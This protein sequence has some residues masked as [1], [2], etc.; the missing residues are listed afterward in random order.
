MLLKL[1][2]FCIWYQD[3]LIV[4][5]MRSLQ[6]KPQSTPFFRKEVATIKE[7][8]GETEWW[9]KDPNPWPSGSNVPVHGTK[10]CEPRHTS[11]LM[12]YGLLELWLHWEGNKRLHQKDHPGQFGRIFKWTH[13]DGIIH[14]VSS[15]CGCFKIRH[16]IVCTPL[17]GFE[18]TYNPLRLINL[19]KQ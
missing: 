15:E 18:I 7:P 9:R 2:P 14:T 13:I 11:Y 4:Y 1:N 5:L 3:I 17:R 19:G 16:T 6:M 12:A 10:S 8:V